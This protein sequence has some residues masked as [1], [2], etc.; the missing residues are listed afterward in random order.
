MSSPN[1][2]LDV[3]EVSP[4][5]SQEKKIAETIEKPEI[6]AEEEKPK[7]SRLPIG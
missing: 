1:K 4:D 5:S 2:E 6:I 7:R 3:E